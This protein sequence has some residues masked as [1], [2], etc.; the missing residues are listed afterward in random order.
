V[1][2]AKG[3]PAEFGSHHQSVGN[4]GAVAAALLLVVLAM[5]GLWMRS[6]VKRAGVLEPV[7]PGGA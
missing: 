6:Q 1:G 4:W 7:E 2:A 5:G 3:T